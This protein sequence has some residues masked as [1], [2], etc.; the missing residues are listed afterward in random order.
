MVSHSVGAELDNFLN[1]I[2]VVP[3]D[4]AI[5]HGFVFKFDESF[6]EIND[7]LEILNLGHKQLERLESEL[8]PDGSDLDIS[9]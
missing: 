6:A 7:F 2:Q 5:F 3:L 9:Y 8:L 1:S 4:Q